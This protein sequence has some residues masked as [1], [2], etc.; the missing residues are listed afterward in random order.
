[1][2]HLIFFALVLSFVSCGG[3]GGSSGTPST[4]QNSVE[5]ALTVDEKNL[6]N[7]LT[8]NN[9]MEQKKLLKIML[10]YEKLQQVTFNKMDKY[11]N[12]DCS[13]SQGICHITKKAQ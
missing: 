9:S 7:E 13:A 6:I 4:T 10:K 2:K 11:L 3:K 1:M 12:I 8:E 5:A